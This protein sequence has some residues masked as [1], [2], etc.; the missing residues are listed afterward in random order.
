MPSTSSG[1]AI[2]TPA[3]DDLSRALVAE[4]PRLARLCRQLT[5]NADA[6][7]DLT[8]ETLL[9]AW[10]LRDRLRDPAGLGAWLAAIARNVCLR[11]LRAQGRER[12]RLTLV[13]SLEGADDFAATTPEERLLDAADDPLAEVERA[14][15][16]ALLERALAT[17]PATTRA[18]TLASA[19]L[20]TAELAQ[21]FQLSEGA[22]RVRLHRGRQ[23]LRLAL[24]GA[25]RPEAEALDLAL[26]AAPN[27]TVSRIYCP[28]CGV[29]RLRYR[30]DRATGEFAFHCTGPCEGTAVAG[31]SVNEPLL[32]Q[33]RSPKSLVT[34]HCLG[35]AVAYREALAGA[36]QRCECGGVVTF[37]AR[38]PEDGIDGTPYGI[39]GVCSRCDHGDDSTAWHLALDTVEAQRFWRRYPR[40]RALPITLVERENRPALVTGFA[41]FDGAARLDIVSD[42]HTYALLH[43]AT[44]GATAS[45]PLP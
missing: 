38:F 26:P 3:T 20:S 17:L 34:R 15:V 39:L 8:Q 19:E 23:A 7:E 24:S 18:L 16:A 2:A 35:L 33:V 42:A 25:L 30:V 6:A 22:A 4:R 14:E 1:L 11:W 9:E 10:R 44:T 36:P 21:R 40:M 13:S 31:C 45:V 27:W 5:Q 43:I 32:R 37:R 12:G 41:A 28:F 29:G